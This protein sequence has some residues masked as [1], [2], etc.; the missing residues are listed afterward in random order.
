MKRFLLFFLLI[1]TAF[2]SF[3]IDIKD[4]VKLGLPANAMPAKFYF[5]Q[6]FNEQAMKPTEADYEVSSIEC[7]D[8]KYYLF[9]QPKGETE[10][11]TFTRISLWLY[12]S[13]KNTVKEVFKQVNNEYDGLFIF[14]IDWLLDKQSTFKKYTIEE[15]KQV[16]DTQEFTFK[17][18]IIMKSEIWTGFNHSREVVI[19]LHPDS[20]K[21]Q[22]LEDQRFVAISHT[23]T[24]ALMGAEQGLAKDY[25]ITTSTIYDSESIELKPNEE[26]TI[27]NKQWVTPVVNIYDTNGTLISSQTLKKQQIDMVR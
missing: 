10:E 11:G 3:A 7:D 4:L 1:G 27:Y 24:Q 19:L 2:S 20:G 25:I 23:S 15:T 14:G 21:V 12:D 17:P 22:L 6:I 16:I 18:V 26:V 13:N 9:A 5:E 8:N